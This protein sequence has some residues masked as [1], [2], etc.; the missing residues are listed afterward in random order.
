MCHLKC[1]SGKMV[2]ILPDISQLLLY[3]AGGWIFNIY[4][5]FLSGFLFWPKCFI[6]RRCSFPLSFRSSLRSVVRE[7]AGG[8]VAAV[9]I[10]LAP[11]V[12]QR[13]GITITVATFCLYLCPLCSLIHFA[14]CTIQEHLCE[15]LLL[16]P[17]RLDLLRDGQQLLRGLLSKSCG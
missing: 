9:P 11:I 13:F 4:S 16:F 15:S 14:S 1:H 2:W 7:V 10:S 3:L 8:G 5:W 6:R 12:A 17:Y